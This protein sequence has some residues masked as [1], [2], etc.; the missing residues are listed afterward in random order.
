MSCA[1][2]VSKVVAE[3]LVM[4]IVVPD[5]VPTITFPFCP[6]PWSEKAIANLLSSNLQ[7]ELNAAFV[8]SN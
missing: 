1:H 5:K 3:S 7:T 2:P 6:S 4:V 8:L